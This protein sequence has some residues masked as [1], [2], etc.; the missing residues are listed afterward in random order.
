MV[1]TDCE[2]DLKWKTKVDANLGIFHASVNIDPELFL[3][4]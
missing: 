3:A 4:I 2:K 1:E